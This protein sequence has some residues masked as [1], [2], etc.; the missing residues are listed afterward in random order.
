MGTTG[1]L[2]QI[3][4][5]KGQVHILA[6]NAK[7]DAQF[8]ADSNS[9]NHQNHFMKKYDYPCLANEKTKSQKY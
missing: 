8:Y 7:Q 9:F 5:W 4:R 3:T 6:L 2:S 1:W